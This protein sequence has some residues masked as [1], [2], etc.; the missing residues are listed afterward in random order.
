MRFA[1]PEAWLHE[2]ES[3]QFGQPAL[4]LTS[5]PLIDMPELVGKPG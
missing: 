5:V 1:L 4:V 2:A 3:G